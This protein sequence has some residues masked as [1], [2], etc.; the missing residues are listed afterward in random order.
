MLCNQAARFGVPVFFLLSGIG[1][2]LSKRPLKLPGFWLRRFCRFGIPY[3][4][5][6]LFY[7]L[8]DRQFRFSG[9]LTTEALRTVGRLILTGG[10]ASHLWFLPVLL[11]LYLLYPGLKWLMQ[12]SPHLTLFAS[13]LLSAFCTLV[14]YAS[15]PF[16]GWWRSRLWR[17]CPTWLFYFVL[18]IGF[19]E[20][21]LEQVKRFAQ[22]HSLSLVLAASGAAF[23]YTWDAQR[24]GNLDSIKPQLFLYSPLC[25]AAAISS[26]KWLERLPG[27]A[28]LSDFAARHS[29]AICF[30]HVFFLRRLRRTSYFDQNAG[31]MLLMF[32]IVFALSLLTAVLPE[33]SSMLWKRKK[34]VLMR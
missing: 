9:L 33:W 28:A 4:L 7:Y 18:G 6:T 14:I 34:T 12:R 29:L 13:F 21:R 17:L 20:K 8:F 31:T 30:S 10:A 26:W 1:L 15:I 5:W 25:F 19:T 16:P 23:L 22:R 2:G 3:V 24:R 11:Q 32:V 27:L